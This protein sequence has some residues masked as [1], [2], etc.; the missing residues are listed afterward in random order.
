[1]KLCVFTNHFF[2]EDFKVNDL[3]FELVK[4]GIE[5]TVITATPDYPNG[6]FYEGY[7]W[8]KKAREIVNGVKV[9]RLPVIARGK[10]SKIM[11]MLNYVSYF[12]SSRVFLFFHKFFNKYDAVFCHMTSPFFIGRC[13]MSLKKYQ[14]IP[15][16]FWVLDLWPES[17]TAAT[18]IKNK[19]LIDS[20]IKMVKKV[21]SYCDKI[22]IGS[23]GFEK[24]IL[25]KGDFK[26]KL[27]YFPNW[28]ESIEYSETEEWIRA[29]PFKSFS[30]KDFIFLFA[31]NIGESQ[32]ID[33][34]IDAAGELR[35]YKNLKFVFLGDGRAREALELKVTAKGLNQTVYFAGRYP[36]ESMPYFMK[37]ADVLLVSL[38][39][40]L[41]FNLTVP[42]K[43]QFYM[44]QG[45]PI[46]A[47]LN[48]DGA[49]LI[50]NAECGIAVPPNNLFCL[51]EALRE[52]YVMDKSLRNEMGK[53]GKMYYDANFSKEDRIEQL[54]KMIMDGDENGR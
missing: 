9:I 42:S 48:G 16:Y 27:V 49:E 22:L 7:G 4:K 21:Y 36:L 35:C 44:S 40:E 28:A 38:K 8:F 5:V 14:K 46:L 39:D 25:E 29:E 1:M 41:I 34:I 10:G 53:N 45:K 18:G 6:K 31:G 17:I 12:F 23:K 37:M 52:F 19:L 33:C 50:K 26:E 24:S 15:L 11:L 32:N 13:A 51:I 54:Y 2:P 47:M 3:S 20:Q 30:K 43:V